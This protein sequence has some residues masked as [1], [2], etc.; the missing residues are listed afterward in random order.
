MA[1]KIEN[2]D[3]TSVFCDQNEPKELFYKFDPMHLSENGHKIVY[4]EIKKKKIEMKSIDIG[5]KIIK[6]KIP[7]CQKIQVFTK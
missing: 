4:K 7:Y 6:E 1:L 5:K 2:Y 3:L